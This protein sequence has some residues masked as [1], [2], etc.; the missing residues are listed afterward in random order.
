MLHS[1]PRSAEL[2]I[3]VEGR[4]RT[5]MSLEDGVIDLNGKRRIIET[6]LKQFQMTPFYQG[7]AH[8]QFNPDCGNV[9]FISVFATE[10]FGTEQT[11][12]NLFSIPND[13]LSATLGDSIEG[14]NLDFVRNRLPAGITQ[15]VEQCLK[16]CKIDK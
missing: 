14:V 4:L 9:T 15:G 2:Q 13:L 10:D 3:V 6:E 16:Q 5:T 12:M 8:T 11:S 7:S 1:H